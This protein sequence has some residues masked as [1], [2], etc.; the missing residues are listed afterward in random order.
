ML[1]D[2]WV[3]QESFQCV[4]PQNIQGY[5]SFLATYAG[6]ESLFGGLAR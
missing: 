5:N 3:G 1:E 6:C 4:A 2:I